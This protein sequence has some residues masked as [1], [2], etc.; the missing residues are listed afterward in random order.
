MKK[1]LFFGMLLLVL[2]LLPLTNVQASTGEEFYLVKRCPDL[3]NPNACDII[4]ASGPFETLVGG[5]ILYDRHQFWINPA[6]FVFESSTIELR[7]TNG[8]AL[9]PG[10]IRWV[11]DYGLF[12][13]LPG[14]GSLAGLHANGRVDLLGF[15]NET[16]ADY[17]LIGKYYF[18]P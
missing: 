11:G 14:S 4:D 16:Q 8:S 10:H 12:T 7:T 9:A 13:L 17:R 2:A 5:Q 1:W 6:G 18:E 3:H 15:V